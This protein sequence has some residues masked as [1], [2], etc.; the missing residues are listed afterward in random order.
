MPKPPVDVE[1]LRRGGVVALREKDMFSVW[2]KTACGNLTSSQLIKLADIS[3]RYARGFLLF[4]TRQI[5]IVPFI[6]L[7]DITEVKR[8]LS[9]VELELDRCGSRVRNTNVCYEDKICP[10]AVVNCINLGEKLES[11]YHSSLLRKVKMGVAGCPRDC[12]V[13]RVLSDVG[14]VGMDSDDNTGYYDVFVG[15]RLGVNPFVGIK[16]AEHL[17]E[18]ECV[19]LMQNYFSLV[20]R[21]ARQNERAAD[22]I[23]KLGAARVREELNRNI[24]L[25]NPVHRVECPTRRSEKQPDRTILKIRATCGEVTSKQVRKLADI[26]GRYGYGFVHFAVWGAPEIPGIGREHLPGVLKELREVDLTILDKGINNLQTCY[27]SY[28][29]ESLADTQSL[30]RRIEKK[31]AEMGLTNMNIRVSAAG[32]PNSCGIAHL[33]DIGFHGVAEPQID[34][35]RCD[36]CGLCLS[37]CKRKAIEI[38]DGLAVI[39]R[40]NCRNCGQCQAV[41]PYDAIVEKRRGFAVLVGGKEGAAD[42]RLGQTI[43]EFLSEDEALRLAEGCLRIIKDRNASL[44]DII[45]ATGLEQFKSMLFAGKA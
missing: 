34:A 32:C 1:A 45:D 40:D 27:G 18:D 2:V 36:G 14:F 16:M 22:L 3:D 4:S 39:E 5:P 11:F 30:L 41:C 7:Q 38:K 20:E 6:H 8:K 15:G 12:V 43:A 28:C 35:G 10:H 44:A 31:V 23:K 37:V 29:S 24:S 21:E 33:A 25:K 19:A 13:S 42:T 9:E 26:A 17:D